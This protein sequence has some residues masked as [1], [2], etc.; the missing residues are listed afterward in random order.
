MKKRTTKMAKNTKKKG[1]D[2]KGLSKAL[3]TNAPEQDQGEAEVSP[4]V[5]A[6]VSETEP[7]EE[8]TFSLEEIATSAGI[9]VATVR[10]YIA[11]GKLDMSNFAELVDF[12][13]HR[14]RNPM[15]KELD[16]QKRAEIACEMGVVPMGFTPEGAFIFQL[17]IQREEGW[18]EL[19]DAATQK[20]KKHG[21]AEGTWKTKDGQPTVGWSQAS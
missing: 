16:G 17:P 4:A 9:K 3:G 13:A 21:Y 12:I 6:A 1:V 20:L 11:Q 19:Y 10:T 8:Y 2:I 7:V 18:V 14:R 5:E 15:V